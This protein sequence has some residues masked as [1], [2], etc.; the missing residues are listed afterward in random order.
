MYYNLKTFFGNGFGSKYNISRDKGCALI[1]ERKRVGG[2]MCDSPERM[3]HVATERARHRAP[4]TIHGPSGTKPATY[5]PGMLDAP[6][7]IND[8]IPLSLSASPPV[9]GNSL[10]AHET[11]FGR[12]RRPVHLNVT[13][14]FSCHQ[15]SR[16]TDSSDANVSPFTYVIAGGTSMT[17]QHPSLTVFNMFE[18]ARGCIL[19]RLVKARV[20]GMSTFVTDVCLPPCYKVGLLWFAV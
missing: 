9:I 3:V 7:H 19:T 2:L 8:A 16:C 6:R 20:R 17:K 12:R 18:S 5:P 4:W 11:A 13:Q 14:P 15:A 10:F 1:E